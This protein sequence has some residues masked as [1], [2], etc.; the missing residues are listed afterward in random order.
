[1]QIARRT[2]IAA[3]AAALTWPALA[4]Q[5][6]VTRVTGT[7]TADNYPALAAFLQ[8]EFDRVVALSLTFPG[9]DA[10]APGVLQAYEEGGMFLAY[11]G[12]PGSDSQIS[13]LSG[14]VKQ[15]KD[16]A[17]DRAYKVIYAGM[18]Q[19]IVAIALEPTLPPPGV[20]VETVAIGR[21]PA[22]AN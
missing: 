4:Q 11:V 6:K 7:V 9:N 10:Y 15:G 12:G 21:L 19:G 22:P 20:P 17:F 13:A 2:L 14:Y 5:A 3:L 18:G 8:E 16:Y 1:M